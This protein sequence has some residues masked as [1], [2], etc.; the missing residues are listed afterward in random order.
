MFETKIQQGQVATHQLHEHIQGRE[1]H[2]IIEKTK[3]E[4]LEQLTRYPLI[5]VVLKQ[6]ETSM[7]SAAAPTDPPSVNKNSYIKLENYCKSIHENYDR[8]NAF[9]TGDYIQWLKGLLEKTP[10]KKE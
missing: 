10:E 3:R 9:I 6:E 1:L 5:C 8:W 7:E 4:L 2:D